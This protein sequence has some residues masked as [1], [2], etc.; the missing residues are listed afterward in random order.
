MTPPHWPTV[1]A[2]AAERQARKFN[3]AEVP[4]PPELT[5]WADAQK[6]QREA[7]ELAGKA[8][9]ATCG[10]RRDHTDHRMS[11]ARLDIVRCRFVEASS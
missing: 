11:S 7:D 8:L 2:R 4:E 9:C 10:K 3:P 6:A 1:N 5:A